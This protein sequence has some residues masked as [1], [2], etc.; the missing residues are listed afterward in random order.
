MELD[1]PGRPARRPGLRRLTPPQQA[2]EAV[3]H[4]LA[5]EAGLHAAGNRGPGMCPGLR[6]GSSRPARPCS[7]RLRCKTAVAS[8]A[9][10]LPLLEVVTCFLA[11]R[12]GQVL[13]GDHVR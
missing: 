1:G 13:A 12:L 2:F 3:L 7:S 8:A 9:G 11:P 6:A 10:I 4:R 5:A